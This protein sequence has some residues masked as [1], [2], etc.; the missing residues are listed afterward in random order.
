LGGACNATQPAQ[1]NIQLPVEVVG[2]NGTT[3]S[4]SFNVPQAANL[5]GA[6]H[7]SMTIHG[8]HYQ[9]QASVQLNNSAWTPINSSTVTLLGLANVFGGIGGGYHTF[10]MTMPLPSGAIT[11]GANTIGFRFNGTDGRASGFRVLDFNVQDSSGNS[12][13]PSSAFTWDDPNTWK[14]PSS[15]ASDIA[16]GKTLW[17]TAALTVPT[18]TGP[19]PIVAHCADCHAQDGRDL[20]YFNYSNNS[21]HARAMFH[22]LTGQQGDQIAS[23]IRSLDVPN[24]GRPWNPPYQPGPGLDSLP[25]A[26]W[27][28]GA[29][30]NAVLQHDADML[31]YLMPSGSTA[32]W[33]PGTP[34][35]PALLSAREM[36]IVMQ[37]PDWNMWLPTVAPV[38]AFGSGFLSSQDYTNYQTI[39]AR[40]VPNDPTSYANNKEKMAL[41]NVYDR[42]FYNSM[43]KPW[44]DPAWNDPHYVA[45]LLGERMWNMVKMWEVNQEFGLEGMAQI[46]FGPLADSRAWYSGEPFFASPNMLQVPP[47]AFGNGLENTVDYLSLVWYHLQLVL[48]YSNNRGSTGQIQSIDWPYST[49]YVNRL[50][51]LDTP[52]TNT[53]LLMTLWLIKGL[54]ASENGDGPEFGSSGW[55]PN[56]NNASKLVEYG[57]WHLDIA[58]SDKIAI[59]EAYLRLWLAKVTSFTAAQF[60]NGNWASPTQI[61]DPIGVDTQGNNTPG[62]GDYVV[63]MIPY[64][65]YEGVNPTLLGQIVTWAKTVWPLYTKWNTIL[66]ASCTSGSGGVK[67]WW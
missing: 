23:Y 62:F 7:L 9:T 50:G 17:N 21:I 8:L 15:L 1:G 60:Y 67:C 41:W 38:D 11:T 16:G 31:P 57:I 52:N 19:K 56:V 37:L 43:R 26:D 4:V 28:A 46:V 65:A 53:G 51:A 47:S 34:S 14:A 35:T 25:V 55:S 30:I 6:M 36:P 54:Q 24:P 44:T 12:L 32:D 40:L 10:Q 18:S 29:G 45:S 59:M 13:L 5:G 64:Y 3:R 61:P 63:Y 33:S 48:N 58:Q 39:R 20:K 66:N 49:S 22:G 42:N 27:S 2:L